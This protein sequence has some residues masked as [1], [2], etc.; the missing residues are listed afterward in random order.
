MKE[1]YLKLVKSSY[2]MLRHRR[3]R[4]RS[5]WRDLTRPIFDRQLWVPCRDTVAS[6]LAVGLFFSM[7]AM[8][9]QMIAAAWVAM[10]LRANVPFAIAGCWVSNLVTHVPIW[11]GQK[12]LGD[13]LRRELGF[14]VHPM[15]DRSVGWPESI[16]PY[17]YDSWSSKWFQKNWGIQI[18]DEINLANFVLGMMVSGILLALLAYPIVHLFSLVMPHHLPVLKARPLRKRKREA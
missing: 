3:L 16:R 11:I 1:R 12:E 7:M 8:P 6:G 14:P 4:H 10:R 18:P 17:L 2:R 5:W 9:L 13:W 15:F